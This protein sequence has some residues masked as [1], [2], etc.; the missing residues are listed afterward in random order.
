MTTAL[1]PGGEVEDGI[2]L[3]TKTRNREMDGEDCTTKSA[4]LG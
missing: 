2:I 3:V 4:P 1:M